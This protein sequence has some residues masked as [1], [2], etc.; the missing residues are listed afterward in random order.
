MKAIQ[1]MFLLK[2]NVEDQHCAGI[3]L[4]LKPIFVCL[5]KNKRE[6]KDN[7]LNPFISS[8]RILL[9]LIHLAFW[10]LSF[11]STKVRTR[12]HSTR[13]PRLTIHERIVKRFIAFFNTN[14]QKILPYTAIG[15]F[16]F[17]V[18]RLKVLL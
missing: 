4:K 18:I 12:P 15:G 6:L 7:T 11:S 14:K 10:K 17:L 13:K 8:S 5:F 1:N 16:N 2:K 3:P 9:Q